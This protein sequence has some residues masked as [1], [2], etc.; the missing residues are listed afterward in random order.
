MQHR[1]KSPIVIPAEARIQMGR[2]SIPQSDLTSRAGGAF[3]SARTREDI[4][5]QAVQLIR[6]YWLRLTLWIAFALGR[7]LA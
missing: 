4:M 6:N 7:I 3:S 1:L 2:G 5:W